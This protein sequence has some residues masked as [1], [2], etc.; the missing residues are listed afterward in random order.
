MTKKWDL[1]DEMR[2]GS[3]VI[4]E[5]VEVGL[6]TWCWLKVPFFGQLFPK[7]K[8]S[9]HRYF[10]VISLKSSKRIKS[11]I[12]SGM[13][14]GNPSLNND[15]YLPELFNKSNKIAQYKCKEDADSWV[16]FLVGICTLS[17][18]GHSCQPFHSSL[19]R[20]ILVLLWMSL[21][22]WNIHP[23]GKCLCICFYDYSQVSASPPRQSLRALVW[24]VWRS[25]RKTRHLRVSKKRVLTMLMVSIKMV[26]L[27]MLTA[28]RRMKMTELREWRRLESWP[29]ASPLAPLGCV[30][31]FLHSYFWK[32]EK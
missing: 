13:A 6:K 8:T 24:S 22:I 21:C 9:S 10:A 15:L 27:M 11:L 5:S 26:V 20:R 1:R 17:R 31:L 16:H 28:S 23:F 3:Q 19:E 4:I 2:D 12:L 30:K 14:E 25:G 18:T 32:Y 29:P 7:T